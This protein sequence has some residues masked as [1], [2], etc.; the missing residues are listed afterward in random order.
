MSRPYFLTHL[1]HILDLDT[2]WV[3]LG[4]LV[5]KNTSR[6][7]SWSHLPVQKS[8]VKV[9]ARKILAIERGYRIGGFFRPKKVWFTPGG[10]NDHSEKKWFIKYWEIL[11]TTH[12]QLL[13]AEI[14]PNLDC[15][16][17]GYNQSF[18]D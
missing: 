3:L 18:G 2:I 15:M 4:I 7:T 12:Q 10:G 13:I 16:L 8:C 11:G 1:D 6:A 14:H 17:A 5:P 9:S